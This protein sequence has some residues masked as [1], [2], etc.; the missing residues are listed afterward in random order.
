A[1]YAKLVRTMQLEV[2]LQQDAL[3]IPRCIH[4]R[5]VGDRFELHA[6]AQS[7][8]LVPR[9]APARECAGF[10]R[11]EDFQQRTAELRLHGLRQLAIERSRG[12][13][14]QADWW[15]LLRRF[16]QGAEMHRCADE[17]ARRLQLLER[18]GDICRK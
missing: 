14:D 9:R 7:P 11:A 15:K 18:A 13:N 5:S 6:F 2:I 12:G 1:M 3:T 8:Y 4:Q 16:D 10:S 17:N